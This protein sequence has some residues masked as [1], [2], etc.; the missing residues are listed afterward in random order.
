MIF[1]FNR[2]IL[3]KSAMSSSKQNKY[4]KHVL[5]ARDSNFQRKIPHHT[6]SQ[7]TRTFKH[8]TQTQERTHPSNY[9][10]KTFWSPLDNVNVWVVCELY[11]YTHTPYCYNMHNQHTFTHKHCTPSSFLFSRSRTPQ[12]I[13]IKIHTASHIC[14]VCASSRLYEWIKYNAII[15]AI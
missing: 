11:Y 3:L 12:H 13:I 2:P 4:K 15:W 10:N 9:H 1:S 14:L 8:N 6:Q 7:H 5:H